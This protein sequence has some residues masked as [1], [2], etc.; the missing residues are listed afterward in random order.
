MEFLMSETTEALSLEQFQTLVGFEISERFEL[1]VSQAILDLANS[2]EANFL[3]KE[4]KIDYAT[5]V[6]AHMLDDLAELL[7]RGN[8]IN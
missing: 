1:Q 5:H 7:E 2:L 3:D 4:T 8:L 6:F